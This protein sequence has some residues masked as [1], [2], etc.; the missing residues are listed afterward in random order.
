MLVAGVGGGSG[1]KL[2]NGI[3]V[4]EGSLDRKEAGKGAGVWPSKAGGGGGGGGGGGEGGG[5]KG[6]GRGGGGTG[7]THTIRTELGLRRHSLQTT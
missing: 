5:G 6:G 3:A 4:G 2:K 7:Q 1:R